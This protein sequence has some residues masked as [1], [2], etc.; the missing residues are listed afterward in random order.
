MHEISVPIVLR[1]AMAKVLRKSRV[2]L[3]CVQAV[4]KFYRTGW[5]E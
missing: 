5:K 1:M 3:T 2:K 4:L